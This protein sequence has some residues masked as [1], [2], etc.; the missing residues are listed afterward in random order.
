MK[1]EGPP[2]KT[3]ER[4]I[5]TEQYDWEKQE[6]KKFHVI[7]SALISLKTSFHLF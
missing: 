7:F 4:D 2:L 1:E 5:K 3:G 6:G